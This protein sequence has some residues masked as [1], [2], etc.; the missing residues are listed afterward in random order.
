M[1]IALYFATMLS[2][3]IRFRNLF[4]GILFFPYLINGVAIVVHLPVLL[5]AG[6]ALDSLLRRRR[7]RRPAAVAR[8]PRLVNIS[9]AGVSVWRYI[10]LNFVLF[11]GA[12]QSIPPRRSRRRRSTAR[13]AGSCSATSSCPASGR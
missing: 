9:L 13:A 11:L 8:R 2:F 10:G 4:K 1:A 7:R 3:K 12:I 5:P 6:G